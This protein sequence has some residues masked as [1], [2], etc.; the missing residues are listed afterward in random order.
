MEWSPAEIEEL[1]PILR[2]LWMDLKPLEGKSVLVLCSAAGDVALWLGERM[3]R[4]QVIGLE[5]SE[6]LLEAAKSSA[7]ERGLHST[8]EFRRAEKERIPLPDETL[9]ALVSEFI[10]FPTPVPTEIGQP[11][12]ARVVKPGGK[13][14]LTDVIVTRPIPQ[15]LR[16]ELQAVGLDYLCE[17]T[18]DDFRRWMKEAGLTD[19]EVIDFTDLLR[20]V[21][22]KRRERDESTE[23]RR[24]YSLLLGESGFRLGEAIFYIYVRGKKGL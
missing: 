20:R 1:S 4:G 7:E 14:L 23:R 18:Q 16:A 21:W 2:Q 24:G 10:V 11:E 13:I 22:E 6:E 5:L 8:V 12:M 19:V 17:G 15:E 3:E 9:D